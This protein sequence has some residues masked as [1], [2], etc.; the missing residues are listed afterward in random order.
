MDEVG[1]KLH[2]KGITELANFLRSFA[3]QNNVNFVVATHSPFMINMDYLEELRIIENDEKN[4]ASIV[5]NFTV[6]GKEKD[7]I[8]N[9][10]DALTI[11]QFVIT[12]P[13][14]IVIFVEGITDYEY[15]TKFKQLYKNLFEHE[16]TFLPIQ[17]VKTKNQTEL[18]EMIEKLGDIR[19]KPFF[20]V[21]GDDAGSKF[22]EETKDLNCEVKTLSNIDSKFKVI[23]DLFDGEDKV[24]F[25]SEKGFNGAIEF[26]RTVDFDDISEKTKANFKKVFE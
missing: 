12:N 11:E 17:G 16:I 3:Q 14:N 15:L 1:S 22:I 7:V 23:E 20:L 26:K 19:L 2:A 21:D 13:K 18:R 25:A 8:G 4:N 6:G 24:K 9:I 10:A 5:D